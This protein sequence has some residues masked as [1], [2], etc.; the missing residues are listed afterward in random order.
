MYLYVCL[1][2]L[3]RGTISPLFGDIGD[4]WGDDILSLAGVANLSPIP[5]AIWGD[6]G[7]PLGRQD[8]SLSNP[9]TVRP[10][11]PTAISRSEDPGSRVRSGIPDAP[12]PTIIGRRRIR[13]R[14][15]PGDL[16]T[17]SE[18]DDEGGGQGLG[19]EDMGR[20]F[21]LLAAD[22]DIP[23][24]SF[25]G[26]L[27][28]SNPA[29]D[30]SRVMFFYWNCQKR[31]R[32]HKFVYDLLESHREILALARHSEMDAALRP[33]FEAAGFRSTYIPTLVI[34]TFANLTLDNPGSCSVQVLRGSEYMRLSYEARRDLFSQLRDK[35]GLPAAPLVA[36][37]PPQGS[38]RWVRMPFGDRI[39][40]LGLLERNP[41]ITKG[42]FIR[43]FLEVRP[44]RPPRVL[45]SMFKYNNVLTTLPLWAHEILTRH[46]DL[47]TDHRIED[48]VIL[49]RDRAR[50]RGVSSSKLTPEFV[51]NWIRFCVPPV[52][53]GPEP[54]E[55]YSLRG[56]VHVRMPAVVRRAHFAWR[57]MKLAANEDGPS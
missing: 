56:S 5:P 25:V 54:C 37:P 57:R 30:E 52:P 32:I 36:P 53:S 9:T 29:L 51:E 13:K 41:E 47:A 3:S 45:A 19:A 21:A 48:L 40:A 7:P 43:E 14:D 39:A 44:G 16:D 34:R 27:I 26:S 55:Q 18:G 23:K 12:P 49:V 24:E 33:I 46:A 28:N 38:K 11:T 35:H 8:G 31:T 20:G 6:G 2:A 10:A 42:E 4:D 22:P 1:V 17:A 50:E 15:R